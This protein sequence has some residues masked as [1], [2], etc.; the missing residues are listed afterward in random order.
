MMREAIR[1]M[2]DRAVRE[3]PGAGESL[4]RDPEFGA[5][6]ERFRQVLV[7]MARTAPVGAPYL[8]TID[9]LEEWLFRAVRSLH[10]DARRSEQARLMLLASYGQTARMTPEQLDMIMGRER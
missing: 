7:L 3:V 2:V 4:L 5:A 9:E 10:D 6:V 8:L 1:D